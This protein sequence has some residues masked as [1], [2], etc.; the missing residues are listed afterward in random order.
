MP[1][2]KL[3][4]RL[5]NNLRQGENSMPNICVVGSVNMD[6]IN[7]VGHHPLAGQTVRATA[8]DYAPGG[9]GANQAV[10]AA[11][12]SKDGKSFL[13]GAVG[14][15]SWGLQL[16]TSLQASGVDTRGLVTLEGDTG[17]AVVTVDAAGENTIVVVPGAN[18]L[19][20]RQHIETMAKLFVQCDALVLQNEIPREVTLRAM[21][22]AQQNGVWVLWNPSPLENVDEELLKLTDLLVVNQTEAAYFV[23][24]PVADV[25]EGEAAAQALCQQGPAVVVVTLGVKGVAYAD[26]FGNAETVPA[27]SVPVI[28]TT[29][30]GDT[31]VGA[32]AVAQMEGRPDAL[33]FAAAAAALTVTRPGAQAAIPTRQETEHLLKTGGLPDRQGEQGW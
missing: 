5:R 20:T 21:E 7:R 1:R 32:F 6:L 16:F 9:K 8:T 33:R 24:H 11:R 14:S 17:L 15:D 22:L 3:F 31:F 30:A 26:V 28:D 4:C 2:E 18:A 29:G 19:V 12:A 23:N 27:F 10:A 25:A 13:V